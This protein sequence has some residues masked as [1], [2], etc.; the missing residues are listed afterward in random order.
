MRRL[1]A[2]LLLTGGPACAAESNGAVMIAVDNVRNATGRVVVELCTEQ[3]FLTDDCDYHASAPAT[4]G[5]TLVL[6]PNVPPGVYAVQA[7]HDRNGNSKVDRGA[8]GRPLEG[9]GFSNDARIG[10][11][12][13]KFAKAGFRHGDAPQSIRLTLKHFTTR[14]G[15][16]D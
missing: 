15:A 12:G 16:V 8:F 2:A 13:P 14:D 4:A 10:L 3:H 6:A 9:V 1:I 11:S 7:F 5:R